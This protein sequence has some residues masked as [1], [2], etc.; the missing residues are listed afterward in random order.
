MGLIL[1]G[2]VAAINVWTDG[3]PSSW[4]KIDDNHAV[5]QGKVNA[6]KATELWYFSLKCFFT[7]ELTRKDGT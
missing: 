7:H 3:V 2:I 6:G 1:S 4:D 5:F